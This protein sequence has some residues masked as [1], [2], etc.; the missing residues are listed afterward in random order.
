MDEDG[1]LV[2]VYEPAAGLSSARVATGKTAVKMA[3]QVAGTGPPVC[4]IEIV[5]IRSSRALTSFSAPWPI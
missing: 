2:N 5:Y 4:R 1:V 3:R